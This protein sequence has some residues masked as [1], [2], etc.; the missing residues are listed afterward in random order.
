MF[1][2]LKRKSLKK[3]IDKN[4]IDRD[5]SQ[6]NTALRTLGFLV[7]EDLFQNFEMLYQYSTELGLQRKDIKIYT[8]K[9]VK[10]K[11]PTLRQNQINNKHFSWTGEILNQ[12]AIEF[13]D[14]PF[15]VLVGY[16]SEENEFLEIMMSRSKAKFRV[17]FA[18]SDKRLLD[19]IID[20]DPMNFE[21][22]K[23]EFKKYLSVLNK[24]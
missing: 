2:K 6:R 1:D 11:I 9:E 18:K 5:L 21:R 3:K 13:L 23:K 15:D 10:K 17:G 16:Y 20:V 4:L 22:F 19:L 8:F 24:I 7:N 12:N 14:T